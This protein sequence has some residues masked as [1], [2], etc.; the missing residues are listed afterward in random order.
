VFSI[1]QKKTVEIRE[2]KYRDMVCSYQLI[3]S[4]RRSYAIAIEENG[5]M[6]VRAPLRASETFL[7]KIL[8]DKEDWI[9]I[10]IEK[11]K[12]KS[13]S[14]PKSNLDERQREELEKRY[15]AAAKEYI[16]K[17]AAYFQSLTGGDYEKIVIRE[18]KT[19]WGSCSSNKTLSFNWKLMLAP[20]RVLDYVVVHELCHLTHMNHSQNFWKM[21]AE[22]L[23]D[24]KE[25]KKWLK[26]NGSKLIL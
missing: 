17:R 10:T 1:R 5:K 15:R 22:I 18:Q 9:K 13:A 20:P 7:N 21:V 6:I 8:S 26:E 23:P 16:P 12:E 3:R 24:Y 14:T 25:Q 2:I 11:Q 19:R 4:D